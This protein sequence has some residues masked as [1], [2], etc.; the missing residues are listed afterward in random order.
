MQHGTKLHELD[1]IDHPVYQHFWPWFVEYFKDSGNK[2]QDLL[3]HLFLW[4]KR[5]LAEWS[6]I[7]GKVLMPHGKA[8]SYTDCKKDGPKLIFRWVVLCYGLTSKPDN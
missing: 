8:R 5:G 2:I 3:T 7:K 6:S 4:A 1:D